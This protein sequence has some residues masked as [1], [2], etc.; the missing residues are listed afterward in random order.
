MG[1]DSRM[2]IKPSQLVGGHRSPKRAFR[3]PCRL[4]VMAHKSLPSEEV[5]YVTGRVG[6]PVAPAQLLI[7]LRFALATPGIRAFAKSER[8]DMAGLAFEAVSAALAGY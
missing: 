5:L 1:G 7:E 8:A 6:L 2:C 3:T 4:F